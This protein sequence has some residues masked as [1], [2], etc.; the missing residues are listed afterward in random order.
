LEAT[1][2]Y[3]GVTDPHLPTWGKLV[4][5]A[6]S[7]GVQTN[8]AHLVIAPFGL[9]FLTGFAFAVVGMTLERLL[10]PRLRDV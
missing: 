7:Y 5:A 3:L 1:L 6:L 10:E 2:A 4:V 9:L 8:T